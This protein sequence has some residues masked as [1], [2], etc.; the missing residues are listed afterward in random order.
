MQFSTVVDLTV[1][2]LTRLFS[3]FVVNALLG[4]RASV[5]DYRVRIQAGNL[6]RLVE[7]RT[8]QASGYCADAVE[9]NEALSSSGAMISNLCKNEIIKFKGV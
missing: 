6:F 7:V 5:R 1:P 3:G 4:V 9:L 2:E 8:L